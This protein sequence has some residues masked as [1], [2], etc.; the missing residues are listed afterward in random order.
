MYNARP[1]GIAFFDLDRTLLSINSGSAWVIREL[2]DGRLNVWQVSRAMYYLALYRL[3]RARLEDAIGHAISTLKGTSVAEVR[4]NQETFYERCVKNAYR[5]GGLRALAEHK[6]QG[7]VTALLSSTSM[8][9][10][11]AVARELG[12]DAAFCNRFEVDGAGAHTGRTQG[13]LCYGLGKLEYA[14]AF[15]QSRGVSLD[16]CVFYT[17]SFSDLPVLERVGRPVVVNPDGRLKREALRR[18]WEVVDWGE[19]PPVR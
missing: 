2:R 16:Q 11:D 9:L 10:A 5:P 7:D 17:D 13:R 6:Q 8:Y 12:L 19:P 15:A 14:E 3:G 1:L 18:K 4:E